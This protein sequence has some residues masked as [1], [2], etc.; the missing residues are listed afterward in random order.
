V[1]AK[2]KI[3]VLVYQNF[4]SIFTPYKQIAYIHDIIFLTHPQYYTWKEKLYFKPLKFLAK[5]AER[6][7]TVSHFEKERISRYY[8]IE[9]SKIDVIHHGVNEMFKPNELQNEA[10][11]NNVKI[12]Y[13][14]PEKYILYVG[15]LNVRK[16]IINMLKAFSLVKNKNISFVIVGNYDWKSENVNSV[17]EDKRIKE[18]LFFTGAV[19]GEELA[20][21]YANASLFCFPSFEESFGLPPLEAMASGVPVVVS[22]S[23]SI[24]EICGEAGNYVDPNSPESIA[25]MLDLLLTDGKLY[26]EK[27]K[28][29]LERAKLFTWENAA[30]KLLESCEKAVKHG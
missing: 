22:N 29:G 10:K 23:S 16:N 5:K 17:L 14:L 6:I 20:A 27:R 25:H 7:N 28:L 21:I 1:A 18:R 26:Q 8:K 30:K 11:I 15:R 4:P 9:Q 19:F 2:N 3:D 13:N 12:K 24:P